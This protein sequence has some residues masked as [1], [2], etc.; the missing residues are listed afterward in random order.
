MLLGS[1]LTLSQGART[2]NFLNTSEHFSWVGRITSEPWGRDTGFGLVGGVN[3][4]EYTN[5]CG[6][7][8]GN[9]VAKEDM[10]KT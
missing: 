7:V 10:A 4:L 1:L 6:G 5:L 3:R 8:Q 2:L 9:K